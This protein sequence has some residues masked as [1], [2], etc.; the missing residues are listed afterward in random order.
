MTNSP[1]IQVSSSSEDWEVVAS[2]VVEKKIFEI[3]SLQK[4]C[5]VFL[6]GGV[7][8]Q[9]LYSYWAKN[10]PSVLEKVCF[11]LGDERYVPVTHEGSNARMVK[12]ILIKDN[13]YAFTFM[14]TS[15]A[16]P[17]AVAQDYEKLIPIKID[18]VLLSVGS[19]GHVASLFP[20]STA[21]KEELRLV[22]ATKG[23]AP[24]EDRISITRSVITQAKSVIL[25]VAGKEKGRVM[26]SVINEERDLPVKLASRAT[27]VMDF[28][29]HQAFLRPS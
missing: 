23:P 29:A 25:F 5:N 12:E 18:I 14:S 21:L 8:A 17:E 3:L 20:N 28:E 19:D 6:T 22:V 27:W 11:F 24:Y 15:L 13:K 2:R 16:T 4:E 7:S 26:A 1:C 10:P 9:R